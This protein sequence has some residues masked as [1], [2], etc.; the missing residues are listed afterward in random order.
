MPARDTLGAISREEAEQSRDGEEADPGE[1]S[2]AKTNATETLAI[3]A[4]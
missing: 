3:R 4:K 2:N 1:P